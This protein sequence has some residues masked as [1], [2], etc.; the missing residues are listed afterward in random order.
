MKICKLAASQRVQGRVLVYWED[1]SLLRVTENEVVAFGLYAGAEV[2]GDTV[3]ALT[4]AAHAAAVREKAMALIAARPMSRKELVGKLTARPRDR[5]KEPAATREEA[6]SAAD[7]LEELGYLNDGEYARTL[8][9]HYA[10]KGY[11]QRKLQDEL[12]RRGVPREYWEDALEEVGDSS[13]EIDALLAKKLRGIDAPDRKDWKRACDALARRGFRWE[14]I[15]AAMRRYG[16]EWE[17]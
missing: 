9:R 3:R 13:A 4:A 7:R 16:A 11:G 5:E 10:A 12:Y 2:D 17:E 15:S 1:G 14:E 6:E 8:V